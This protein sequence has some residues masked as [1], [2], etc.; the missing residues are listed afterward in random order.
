MAIDL[1]TAPYFVDSEYEIDQNYTQVLFKPSYAVQARELSILQSI[2]QNQISQLGEYIFTDGTP[3]SGGHVSVDTNVVALTLNPTY[4]NTD[5]NLNDFLLNGQPTLIVNAVGAV[6]TKAYVLA[7]DSSQINPV[8]VVKYITGSTFQSG[9]VIQV[10]SGS[11]QTQASLVS[12]NFS[13]PASVASINSGIFYSGGYF[14]IVKPQTILLSS[15]NSAPTFNIGLSIEENIINSST[16][17]TLLD[18]AQGSFNYQAPGADRLQYTM[19]LDKRSPG[20]TDTSTF[21]Q[22]ICLQNGLVTSQVEYPVLGNIMNTLAQR[23][24]DQSGDFTVKPFLVTTAINQANSGNLFNLVISPGKAYVKG[25]EFET[26]GSTV[27]SAPRALTTNTVTDYSFSTDFGNYV[28]CNNVYGGNVT[29]IVDITQYGNVDLHLCFSGNINTTNAATYNATKIGTAGIRDIEFLGLG[30]YYVYLCNVT[31]IPNTF[32]AITGNTTNITLPGIYHSAFNNCFAN[33][34]I[35]VN[36]SNIIETRVISSYSNSAQVAT[37]STPLTL[38]PTSTSNC[39]LQYGMVNLNGLVIPPLASQLG[40]NVYYTQNATSALQSCMDVAIVGQ[41]ITG[42]TIISDNSNYKLIYSLPDSWVTQGSITNVSYFHRKNLWS[43]TFTS[44]NLTI[45]SGT[46]LAGGEILP[47]GVTSAFLN[48]ITANSNF[49]VWVRNK[50]SSNLSNGQIIQWNKGTVSGGNGIYQTS[51]V[52]ATI[53]VFNGAGSTFV[54]DVLF[55]VEQTAGQTNTRRTK[56]LVGNSS[57]TALRATDSYLNGS[58]VAGTTANVWIDASNGFVWF[59]NAAAQAL[60][61][62]ASQSMFVPDVFNVIKVYDSGNPLYAPNATNA[63]DITNRY[64]LNSGQNDNFYDYSALVLLSG[65]NPPAGQTV[66]MVQYYNFDSTL[67]F[68][69]A[70]SYS[71][72]VYADGLIP[73]YASQTFGPFSL[74]DSIDFRPNR[75]IGTTGNVAQTVFAGL[76][77]PNPYDTFVLTFQFYLPR[78]DKLTLTPGGVFTLSQGIPSQYPV[79]PAD[80]SDAMTLYII[81]VPAYTA[82]VDQIALQYVE[83]KRYT[84][85]DIGTLDS[86]IQTLET[87]SQLTALENQATSEQILYQGSFT[88]KDIYGIIADNFNSFS[89]ADVQTPDLQCYL[90]PG[91]MSPFKIETAFGLNFNSNTQPYSLNNKT[92]CLPFTEVPAISQNTVV[93]TVAIQPYLMGQFIGTVELTPDSDFWFSGNLTPQI[94]APP[95]CTTYLPPLPPEPTEP[96][97]IPSNPAAVLPA[98]PIIASSRGLSNEYWETPQIYYYQSD[99]LEYVPNFLSYGVVS[100]INN[101]FGQT[102]TANS[103]SQGVKTVFLG[104]CIPVPGGESL[105]QSLNT[106]PITVTLL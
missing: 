20:S 89:V 52:S 16:D 88:A 21:Y 86:R 106:A 2:L 95:T 51:N 43:Q 48:D 97:L 80:S 13:S 37:F 91:T 33:V 11:V 104:Q 46:G 71:S 72:A 56:T 4:A 12:T 14:V 30:D 34:V 63:I 50:M 47:Y 73:Y 39:T 58:L 90:R 19:Y 26:V 93:S 7:V 83:N 79:P 94:I 105:G 54:G 84:M 65:V 87:I 41:T 6:N 10:A 31:M 49:I 23:T 82:N 24:Y 67:G 40:G 8:I 66:A 77:L 74:R 32:T 3:V 76:C 18:P 22:L 75:V 45:A 101:W 70:D 62:G 17:S 1:D 28:T 57:I 61:P 15:S 55:N 98:A 96:G 103:I 36:T 9:Q 35:T 38:A 29:G 78:I 99:V 42:N 68:F 25:Y 27:L 100:T 5:I 60:T 102:T 59:A 44:G 81:S 85:K 92:Y 64:Y 53:T 69:D